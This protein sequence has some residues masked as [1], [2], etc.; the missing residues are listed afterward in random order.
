MLLRWAALAGSVLLPAL[1]LACASAPPPAAAPAPQT[2]SSFLRPGIPVER[3]I[4]GGETHEYPLALA[5]GQYLRLRIDQPGV[6]ITAKLVDAAGRE[7]AASDIPRWKMEPEILSVLSTG[8]GEVRLVVAPSLPD[9]TPGRYR[10]E[11]ELRAAEPGDTERVAATQAFAAGLLSSQDGESLARFREALALW[12]AAGDPRG[13]VEALV[14]IGQAQKDLK[15][16]EDALLS[17]EKALAL[18]RQAG[19]RRGEALALKAL[20]DVHGQQQPRDKAIDLYQQAVPLW[21]D[22]GEDGNRGSALYEIGAALYQDQRPLEALPFLQQALPLRQAA[23]DVSGEANVL[24]VIGVIETDEGQL[25]QA[26]EHLNQALQ[27]SRSVENLGVQAL[28]LYSLGRIYRLRGDLDEALSSFTSS[29]ELNRQAGDRFYEM[30]AL[31][32]L[33]SIYL[34]L[35]ETERALTYYE[36]VRSL[37]RSREE[38]TVHQVRALNNLGWTHFTLQEYEKALERCKEALALG[39]SIQD[40][41]LRAQTLHYLGVIETAKTGPEQGL[42]RLLDAL[43]MRREGLLSDRTLSL[44]E[45]GTAYQALGNLEEADEFLRQACDLASSLHNAVYESTC[46][47]RWALLDRDRGALESALEKIQQSIGIVESVRSGVAS[48]KLRT[49]FFATKRG[50]YEL[51]VDLLMRL[52]R[53]EQAFEA[54]E[55]ARARGLMDLLAEG[56]IDVRQGIDP[57]LR[58]REVDLEAR[59]AWLG[60]AAANRDPI[61][62]ADLRRQILEVEDELERLEAEI[63][64]LHPLYAEVRYPK[65][66]GA[67]AAQRLLDEETA[68][69]QYFVSEDKSYLFVLTS[70]G[71]TS[72]QLPPAADIADR[73]RKLRQLLER[74]GSLALSRY[75]EEAHSLHETLLGPAAEVLRRKPHLLVSPDGA[76]HLL[77]FEALLTRQDASTWSRLPYLLR[78]HVVSYIPSASVL[79]SLRAAR[80]ETSATQA[81]QL[82]AFADPI[83]DGEPQVA[84]S[85]GAGPRDT[86]VLARLPESGREVKAIAQLFRDSEVALYLRE[87]ATEANVKENPYLESARR[88]HFA[89]HG[90]LDGVHPQLSGLVLTRDGRS[91]EDGYLRVLE[92]FNLKLSA[93]LVTLSACETGLGQEVRSEGIIGL[94]RAFLYAGA[95]SLLV[96]LWKAADIS[97]PDL[98]E[99]FY[100]HLG[101]SEA[102]AEALRD[103]K[104]EMIEDG[105]YAHPYF[106]APFVLAGNP[107]RHG[108]L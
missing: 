68:L 82:L 77:P 93:E 104:I 103:S 70:E 23:G 54:S 46:L 37:A 102:R 55:G 31:N 50:H 42:P 86:A 4:G 66:L 20:G 85:R 95:R 73:V 16:G 12:E 51:Y 48:D 74:P 94:T 2:S 39:K 47:Y 29:R 69:L 6:D 45:I 78:E 11:V 92:I 58:E 22:L 81:K 108:S 96:S 97:T 76:L 100:R 3:E 64:Q 52:G 53:K 25:A 99:S 41:R 98:M 34:N 17:C 9:T 40:A 49:S 107:G 43:E 30:Y 19:Y 88:I 33:G 83:Y 60:Q 87:S 105:P 57:D 89:T 10:I 18:A 27:L 36:E 32:A 14:R 28:A 24:N 8:T 44:L 35:G 13:Q 1:G 79:S 67:A 56:R 21:E 106:W 59:L 71:L 80:P 38:W 75:R 72:H 65:P 91:K 90:M 101:V 63:R 61:Q 7:L 84:T 62:A 26:F 15:S 5:A